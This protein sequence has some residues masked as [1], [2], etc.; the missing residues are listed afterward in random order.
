MAFVRQ[1]LLFPS[2]PV[3]E[4]IL[5]TLPALL[6]PP[7]C[8]LA[9]GQQADHGCGRR[10]GAMV[11]D[12]IRHREIVLMPQSGHD[13]QWTSRQITAER[14]IVEDRK[15]LTTATTPGQ[16]KSIQLQVL[17]AS[18]Q[19]G[20]R[21]PDLV[22]H[23]SLNRDRNDDQC[24]HRPAFPRCA[25]HVRQ[26]RARNAGEDCHGSGLLRQG[27]FSVCIKQAGVQQACSN[28]FKL[29]QHR[30]EAGTDVQHLHVETG[31]SGPEIQ[32]SDNNHPITIPGAIVQL[33]QL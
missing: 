13:R 10:G 28:G 9:V 26:S 16:N 21:S 5:Q 15:I 32:F 6:Q 11:C 20:K 25:Q 29:P 18:G 24:R 17:T 14:F 8:L 27:L 33:F 7:Q 3:L 1:A 4:L 22:C 31:P 30:R 23:G 19:S 12:Q 2:N